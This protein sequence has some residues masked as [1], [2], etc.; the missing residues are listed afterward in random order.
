[1]AGS[2]V[3][4]GGGDRDGAWKLKRGRE[5]ARTRQ[6]HGQGKTAEQLLLS[7]L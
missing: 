3:L 4:I 6:G 1:M 7:P 2:F 5:Q